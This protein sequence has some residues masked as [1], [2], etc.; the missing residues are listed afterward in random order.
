M[1]AIVH[2]LHNVL[3]GISGCAELI[4]CTLP[5]DDSTVHNDADQIRRLAAHAADLMKLLLSSTSHPSSETQHI[6]LNDLL[7][8]RELVLRRLCGETVELTVLPDASESDID[9]EPHQIERVL[10]NLVMNAREAMPLGGQLCI[11][12]ANIQRGEEVSTDQTLTPGRY[13]RLSVRD[14][15]AGMD[16]ATVARAT[17]PWFTTKTHGAGHGL[18][19]AICAAIV[20]KHGGALRLASTLGEGT[21]VLIDLPCARSMPT[22]NPHCAHTSN[23]T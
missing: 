8:E 5:A 16:A 12:T 15:G 13:V 7:L 6:N 22:T 1:Q 21:T 17:E 9:A 2:D 3:S 11:A 10:V 20:R 14:T 4:A 23:S 19:L 18:G